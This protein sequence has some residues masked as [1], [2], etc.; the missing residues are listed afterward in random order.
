M[1][2]GSR[3]TIAS[4]ATPPTR[5]AAALRAYGSG[6]RHSMKTAAPDS[7][8]LD[9]YFARIGYQGD[10][11]PTAATLHAL[12]RDHTLRIPFENLDLLLGRA[13]RL[14]PA[15][16]EAKLVRERRG[17]YCFEQN[18]LLAAVLQQLGFKV[19]RLT[20]Q[21]RPGVHPALPRAHMVLHVEADG[22][23]WLADVGFGGYGLIEPI[24]LEAGLETTQGMWTFR[25]QRDGKRWTLE[26]SQ[27]AAGCEQYAFTLDPQ[28][29]A[30]LDPA[31]HAAA[32]SPDSPFAQTLTVQLPAPTERRILHDRE[33]SIVDVHGLHRE[34]IASEEELLRVLDQVFGLHLPAGTRFRPT[35]NGH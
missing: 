34:F 18:G 29:A 12:H 10:T 21:L 22:I 3:R 8:D 7:L 17:G 23:S 2:V 13:L 15:S 6:I 26:C 14:D 24:P 30:D 4:T 28:G 35:L 31:N 20:A 16:L 32:T 5:L 19:T 25:L 1:R 9:A 33:L 11:L 27:C